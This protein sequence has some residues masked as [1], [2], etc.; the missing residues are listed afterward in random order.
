MKKM[1]TWLFLA[2]MVVLAAWPVN[3][4]AASKKAKAL[5]AYGSYMEKQKSDSDFAVLY[6]DKDSVPE[7][8]YREE[9]SFVYRVLTWEKGKIRTAFRC[10][11]S[12]EPSNG[13][14]ITHYY[15]KKAVF[16]CRPYSGAVG[17][18]GEMYFCRGK[19]KYSHKLNKSWYMPGGKGTKETTC[20][21]VKRSG[22]GERFIEISSA[23]FNSS[24]KKFVGSGKKT[25][26][27]YYSNTA[28]N[29]AKY[30]K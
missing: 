17:Y 24:L 25:K 9:N 23:K 21:E 8:I 22:S 14:D 19:N 11:Y 1:K 12:R 6:L 5:K 3:V 20:F 2:V 29:R 16:T 28:A 10:D 30:L 7:L 26:I 27:R 4:Q 15:K 18:G 13:F